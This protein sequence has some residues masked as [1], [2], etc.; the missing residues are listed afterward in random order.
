MRARGLDVAPMLD[1]ELVF[2]ERL[3]PS[4]ELLAALTAER[5]ISRDLCRSGLA[6]VDKT[7]RLPIVIRD[8]A[9]T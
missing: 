4:Q 7:T 3:A 8:T 1:F 2:L 6:V 9:L 5:C